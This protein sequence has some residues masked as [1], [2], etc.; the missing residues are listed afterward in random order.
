MAEFKEN[1]P[2]VQTDPMVTVDISPDRPLSPGKHTFRLVVVDDAGNESAPKDVDIIVRDTEKPT[3]VLDMVNN[4]GA[5]VAATAE[6]GKPF[7]LSAARSS[8]PPPGKIKEYRFT[9]LSG[10]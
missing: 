2:V 10:V 8:D 7:I 6:L 1:V 9:L 3:A 4:D 5:V